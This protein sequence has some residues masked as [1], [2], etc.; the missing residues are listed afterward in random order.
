M[1]S[2]ST[3]LIRYNFLFLQGIPWRLKEEGHLSSWIEHIWGEEM[4]E[5]WG[6]KRDSWKGLEDELPL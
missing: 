2:N 5:E 3:M 4:E 1:L 6:G